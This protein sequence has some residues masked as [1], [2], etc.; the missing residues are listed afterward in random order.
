MFAPD[1]ADL[2]AP[3]F[4]EGEE[5]PID[6]WG[7]EAEDCFGYWVDVEGGGDEVE[8]GWLRREMDAAEVAVALEL[9]ETLPISGL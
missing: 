4:V 7:E 6:A 3:A 2:L 8:A 5:V 1:H 9:A